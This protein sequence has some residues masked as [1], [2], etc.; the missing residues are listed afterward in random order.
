MPVATAALARAVPVTG[1]SKPKPTERELKKMSD[2]VV[3]GRRKQSADSEFRRCVKACLNYRLKW[4]T[5]FED[6]DKAQRASDGCSRFH[7]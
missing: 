3:N 4:D 7:P 1:L 5:V 2:A 6:D